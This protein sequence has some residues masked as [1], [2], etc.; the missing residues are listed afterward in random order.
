MS[1]LTPQTFISGWKDRKGG[2]KNSLLLKLKDRGITTI[3]MKDFTTVLTIRNE[4]RQEILSQI[5]EIADGN[6]KKVLGTGAEIEWEGKLGFITGV[7]GIIDEHHA[8]HQLLGER[9]LYYRITPANPEE[10]ARTA[11][12]FA[13]KEHQ[14]RSEL[15]ETVKQFLEQFEN[16]KI[17]DIRIDS[18]T[19]EKLISLVQFVAEGRTAVT[20]SRYSQAIQYPPDPEGPS[21]IMKQL[22]KLGC[23][24]AIIQGKGEINKEIYGILKKVGK[25][26]L[27]SYRKLVI[28]KMWNMGIKEDQWK[29]T[30][31]L[32]DLFQQPLATARLHLEDLMVLGMVDRKKEKDHH[33]WRLS[34][35]CCDLIQRIA[36]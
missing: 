29:E 6:Y 1:S 10:M 25:D 24:I 27:P 7:T 32:A 8:V 18:H 3:A 14:M 28:G 13:G 4:A 23:G 30:K 26:S 31:R 5:R 21:R 34:E 12:K 36:N 17:E 35:K 15:K 19:N 9:F 2:A 33:L 16:P 22:F 20:R 11:Q